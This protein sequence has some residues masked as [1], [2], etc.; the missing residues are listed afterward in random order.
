MID[1]YAKEYMREYGAEKA[2]ERW[3]ATQ[4]TSEFDEKEFEQEYLEAA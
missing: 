3:V 4:N 1:L 2:Y